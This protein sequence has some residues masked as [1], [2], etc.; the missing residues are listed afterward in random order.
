M[1][2]RLK[3]YFGIILCKFT[4]KMCV[5]ILRS[6]YSD[7]EELVRIGDMY[8][9]ACCNALRDPQVEYKR[10]N[11]FYQGCLVATQCVIKGK[12]IIGEFELAQKLEDHLKTMPKQLP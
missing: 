4:N 12:R 5:R 1:L 8:Y 3:L 11:A 6:N 2:K 7:G 9:I 10:K